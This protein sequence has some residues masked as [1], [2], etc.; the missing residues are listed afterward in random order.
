MTYGV[1]P[2]VLDATVLGRVLEK[3]RVLGEK[4]VAIFDLDST[5]LDN[6]NRQAKILSEFGSSENLPSLAQSTAAHWQ[7]WDI[8]V[9]MRNAGLD[10]AS[11]EKHAEAA[12]TYW[13]ERFFTSPY[14]AL[15]DAIRGASQYLQTLAATG[16]RIVYCTGRHEPMREGSVA[17]FQRHGFPIPDGRTELLMKPTFELS[18]DDWKTQAYAKIRTL[19]QVVAAFDN[20]P[21]HVNGYR[22]AFPEAIIVHL[23]TDDSGRP[24][25]LADGIISVHDFT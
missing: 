5:L 25:T 9:A 16:V 20:E 18:D 1:K 2:N 6:R 24:V 14:A 3:A 22:S 21:T 19:G 12:K 17:S 8:K 10:E 11:I 7:G 13:R 23:A 15:D 4:G